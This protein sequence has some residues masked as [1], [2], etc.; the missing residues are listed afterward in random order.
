MHHLAKVWFS[1]WEMLF[2][3]I[4]RDHY[5]II[6]E[7]MFTNIFFVL[8]CSIVLNINANAVSIPFVQR[9]SQDAP[10]G[11]SVRKGTKECADQ[12]YT[13]STLPE[14]F[15][16]YVTAKKVYHQQ[17]GWLRSG[18]SNTCH[19]EMP[20][21]AGPKAHQ[22]Q[23]LLFT[24]HWPTLN[25]RGAMQDCLSWTLALPSMLSSLTDWSL[26]WVTSRD[27]YNQPATGSRTFKLTVPKQSEEITTFPP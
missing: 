8:L 21:D 2:E 13:A 11:K 5:C 25:T 10:L 15:N 12:V 20:W 9:Y 23:P 27:F 3:C 22:S 17:A 16:N 7:S 1:A 14:V 19:Y 6:Y 24:Q 4:R 18:S 26:N